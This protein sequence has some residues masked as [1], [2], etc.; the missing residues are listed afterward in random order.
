MNRPLRWGVLG[1]SNFAATTMAPALHEAE[2]AELVAL[3]TS[4]P[5]KA[6]RFRRFH[7]GLRVESYEGLLAASDIDAVY[8]PLPNTLHVEW[9][10]RAMEAGKHVLV[11][12]PIAMRAEE[13]DAL[14]ALRDG[15]GLLCAEAYMIVHHPQWIRAKAM[16]AE[17][18]IGR[19]VHVDVAFSYRNLDAANIRNRADVGGGGLRD[20]GC[21]ALGSVRFATGAE[22]DAVDARIAWEN[23]VDV[24]A[25]VWAEFPGFTCKAMTSTRMAPRQEAVFHGER[26][27]LRVT[28]PYNAAIFGEEKLVLERDDKTIEHIRFPGTRQYKLQVENFVRAAVDGAPYPWT[29]EDARGTQALIDRVFAAAPPP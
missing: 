12:K 24:T 2:G 4:S 19:L 22:P 15:A 10:A 16:L 11:E 6:E 14:I 29:L 23:G 21:Y 7:P 3:G 26:A 8:I 13:I 20:I 25:H 1:A 28:A 18:A 9:A 5:D 27:V 17:G